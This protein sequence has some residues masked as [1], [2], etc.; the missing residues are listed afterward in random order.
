M[1]SKSL[2]VRFRDKDSRAGVTRR[3]LKQVADA[4]GVSE[5]EAVHQAL[6]EYAARHVPGYEAD[7]GPLSDAS[8]E[9]IREAVRRQH[10]EARVVE[11]LFE[12]PVESAP[13]RGARRVSA[14]RS[15]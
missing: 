3:T 15:R 2:L 11:S 10:G 7:E 9:R 8:I 1:P 4:L 14:S 13:R 12:E 6:A 5:T